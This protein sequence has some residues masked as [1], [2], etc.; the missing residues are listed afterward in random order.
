M[1]SILMARILVLLNPDAGALAGAR[2]SAMRRRIGAAFARHGIEARVENVAPEAI[3]G[4]VRALASFYDAVVIGGGDG[5]IGAAAGALAG[6]TVPLGILPLGTF[7]HFARDLGL[8]MMVESAVR[9][10]A[11]GQVRAV[12][13]GEVNGRIFVNNTSLGIYPQLVLERGRSRGLVR[14]LAA[15]VAFFR[16]LWRLPRPRLKIVMAAGGGWRKTSCLFVGNNFYGLDPLAPA[17]RS[18]LDGGELCLYIVNG[19]TRRT[20]LW[21]AFRAIFRRLDPGRELTLLRLPAVTVITKRRIRVAIDGETLKLRAPLHFRIRPRHLRVLAPT[22][23]GAPGL[24]ERM[25]ECG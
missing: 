10:V 9:I 3:A 20:L 11:A 7:N 5:S 1:S 22:P 15:A 2:D 13:V 24:S 8:P 21:L 23:G 17:W 25:L 12:D 19:D 18:R 6:G 16:V 4:T 14:L